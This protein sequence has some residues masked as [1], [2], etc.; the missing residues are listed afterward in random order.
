M[1]AEEGDNE[2]VATPVSKPGLTVATLVALGLHPAGKPTD[3]LDIR[4]QPIAQQE[5]GALA[6]F[7][8]DAEIDGEAIRHIRW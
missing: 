3:A 5:D 2:V 6:L 4:D 1:V 8:G 7:P